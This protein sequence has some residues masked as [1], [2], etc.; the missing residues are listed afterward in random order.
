ML[1]LFYFLKF[2]L[3]FQIF[4]SLNWKQKAFK[5]DIVL[6]IKEHMSKYQVAS[7]F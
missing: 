5:K 7:S 1:I 3:I 2:N 6:H 4:K